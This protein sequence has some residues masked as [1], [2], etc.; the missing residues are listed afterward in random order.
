MAKTTL[1]INVK[2]SNKEADKLA[3]S[4]QQAA[5][6]ADKVQ[7][8]ANKASISNNQLEISNLKV[9]NAVKKSNQ[10]HLTLSQTLEKVVGKTTL[11]AISFNNITTAIGKVG[12][13]AR[14]VIGFVE[15]MATTLHDANVQKQRL[16]MLFMSEGGSTAALKM[17]DSWVALGIPIKQA[18]DMLEEFGNKNV[19]MDVVKELG[20]MTANL[21]KSGI[22]AQGKEGMLPSMISSLIGE[23]GQFKSG[24]L[25]EFFNGLGD[26]S[27]KIFLKQMKMSQGEFQGL[28]ASGGQID[29]RRFFKG[30]GSLSA[31]QAAATAGEDPIVQ[32]EKITLAWDQ[33]K[34]KIAEAIFF[35]KD[36]VSPM[37][38]IS[39]AI[40]KFTSKPENIKGLIDGF[41]SFAETLPGIL[42]NLGPIA[43]LLGDIAKLVIIVQQAPKNVSDI[44]AMLTG[45]ERKITNA[46]GET[47]DVATMTQ[48]QVDAWQKKSR[49]T[50]QAIMQGEA[51]GIKNNT[52]LPV[53]AAIDSTNKVLA[54]VNKTA[55]VQS[56]SKYTK[57]T[58][59]YLMSGLTV[60]IDGEAPKTVDAMS[61]AI[62]KIIEVAKL[63]KTTGWSWD[64]PTKKKKQIWEQN[65]M[66][67]SE[68]KDRVRQ[69]AFESNARDPGRSAPILPPVFNLTFPHSTTSDEIVDKFHAYT[70]ST[71]GRQ[72]LSGL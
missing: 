26:K 29:A 31:G 30:A 51:E 1:D 10:E 27:K 61:N 72:T 46:Q 50:G 58:G 62:N 59:M 66:S 69:Q 32:L 8:S 28:I 71:Q 57:K 54:A 38:M 20:E 33:L 49:E 9:A 36:G 47:I 15:S 52:N 68:Y 43:K 19:K 64:M 3:K 70:V 16:D 6:A 48:E 45:G 24:A 40:V 44:Y 22:V 25:L 41:K 23:R 55:G 13:A 42:E 2:A 37:Q 39:D 11:A 18:N 53:K 65:N 56:P 35:T 7:I 5:I 60:G 67:E 4:L 17:R 34:I 21:M 63:E 12:S 14:S